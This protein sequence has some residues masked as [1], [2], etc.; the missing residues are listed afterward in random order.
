MSDDVVPNV[1]G[2]K[3]AAAS[4]GAKPDRTLQSIGMMILALF[5]LSCMDGISKYLSR[6]YDPLE[7]SF[8][9]SMVTLIWLLPFLLWR[10]RRF[11][12]RLAALQIGRGVAMF[13]SATFFIFGVAH[14]PIATATAIGFVS[15]LLVTAL[16]IPLLR[17]KVGWRRWGAIAIGFAGAMI[18]VRPGGGGFN[19][20][21]VW[22][23]MS[24]ASWATGAVL[25]RRIGTREPMVTTMFYTTAT[26]LAIA[27]LGMPLVWRTPDL[28]GFAL[29]A[30]QGSLSALAHSIIVFAFAR[31]AA[32]TLAP[33]SY[34]QMLW[35]SLIGYLVFNTIPDRTT[36]LGAAIIIASG[37]YI[38]HRERIAS[39]A[40]AAAHLALSEGAT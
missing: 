27:A 4:S 11:C 35:S 31:T 24:A 16:S 22:P 28:P 13:G 29:M 25:T 38:L 21:A 20:A 26:T 1:T 40:A 15:P 5:L 39:R 19:A 17:E 9:R 34:T 2:S 30:T 7:I 37:L 18:I 33:F 32:S 12:T 3:S 23:L 14:L 10:P 8:A 36:W 6:S